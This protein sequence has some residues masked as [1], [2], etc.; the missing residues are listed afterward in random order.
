MGNFTGVIINKVN[1]GLGLDTAVSYTQLTLPTS[2]HGVDSGCGPC[3]DIKDLSSKSG[4]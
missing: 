1:G 3:L 2:G 4:G